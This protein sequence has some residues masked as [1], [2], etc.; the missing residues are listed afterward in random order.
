[1]HYSVLRVGWPGQWRSDLLSSKMGKEIVREDAELLT[2]EVKETPSPKHKVT[3]SSLRDLQFLLL[4][5]RALNIHFLSS[6]DSAIT[7]LEFLLPPGALISR[8]NRS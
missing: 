2:S 4:S 8:E 7:G 1:M 3:A 5:G 6:F